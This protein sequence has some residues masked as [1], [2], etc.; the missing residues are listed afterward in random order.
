MGS[1]CLTPIWIL[2]ESECPSFKGMLVVTLWYIFLIRAIMCWSTPLCSR[3]EIMWA[4]LTVSN[5][6][7]KSTNTT[8][9]DWCWLFAC[10]II[11]CSNFK[12]SLHPADLIKPL[13]RGLMGQALANL[14]VII[15]ENSR[16]MMEPIVIGR[17][18]LMSPRRS[19]IADF[20][21]KTVR[22]FLTESGIMPVSNHKLNS[23]LRWLQWGSILV[24]SLRVILSGPG[25]AVLL[26][27]L[28]FLE[29]SLAEIT[30]LNAEL[31]AR[32]KALKDPRPLYAPVD[33]HL[34]LNTLCTSSGGISHVRDST[35]SR[36]ILASF[37]LSRS[38]SSSS[39]QHCLCF[40]L[41]VVSLGREARIRSRFLRAGWASRLCCPK[42]IL[43]SNVL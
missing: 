12:F 5:A 41:A 10:R 42:P 28:M 34:D 33:S 24:N 31:S 22:Q 35:S 23:S 27:S 36:M 39:D 25:A 16:K 37:P 29:I 17:Q 26:I 7:A 18:L 1:P 43:V 30:M 14:D 6:L 2:M 40:P 21:I 8:P 20:A 19:G 38:S 11:N 4:W 15:L 32:S 3:A 13:C 9:R